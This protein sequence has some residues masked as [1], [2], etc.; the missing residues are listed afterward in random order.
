MF[1]ERAQLRCFRRQAPA[2]KSLIHAPGVHG[3]SAAGRHPPAIPLTP[4]WPGTP[5]RG[6][7]RGVN[8]LDRY[9]DAV[10]YSMHTYL[11]TQLV[12]RETI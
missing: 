9:A 6:T 8:D 10:F 2:N 7:P 12:M 11:T 3:Y 5:H 1:L 4:Q